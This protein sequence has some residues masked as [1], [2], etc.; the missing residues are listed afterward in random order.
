MNKPS[1]L[2]LLPAPTSPTCCSGQSVEGGAGGERRANLVWERSS[3]TD[4]AGDGSNT[5]L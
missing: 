4:D 1:L 2:T 3:E 5:P